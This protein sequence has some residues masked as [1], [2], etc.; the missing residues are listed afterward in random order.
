MVTQ[1]KNKYVQTTMIDPLQIRPRNNT[2]LI[3]K[4]KKN[5]K[6]EEK[7]ESKILCLKLLFSQ[8]YTLTATTPEGTRTG[9]HLALAKNSRRGELA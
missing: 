9:G 3:V 2:R 8:P 5:K 7:E 6:V 4:N 1:N